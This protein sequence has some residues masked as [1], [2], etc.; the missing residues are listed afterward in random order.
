VAHKNF[1]STKSSYWLTQVDLCHGHKTIVLYCVI[2][3][4]Y[5]SQIKGDPFCYKIY[6]HDTDHLCFNSSFFHLPFFD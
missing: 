2:H 5:A 6:M 1:A 4:V 3:C